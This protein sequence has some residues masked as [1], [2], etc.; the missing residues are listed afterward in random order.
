MN[1][2]RNIFTPRIG[3]EFM[4]S[5]VGVKRVGI[6]STWFQRGVPYQSRFLSKALSVAHDVYIFAYK[7]LTEDER[8]WGY[9]KLAFSKKISS[10]KVINWIKKDK[11]R[12]IFFPD[13]LEDKKVLAFCEKANIATIMVINYET[14]CKED[15][16]FYERYTRLL[17]PVKCT[18]DALER[19]GIK[20]IHF[21]RWAVD[22]SVYSPGRAPEGRSPVRFIHNA[23]FGGVGFRKNTEAVVVAFDKASRENKNIELILKTQKPLKNYPKIISDIVERNPQIS[24]NEKDLGL[25]DLLD[26]TRSCHVSLLPSKWEGIGLPFLESLSMGLPVLTVDAPP[27]NEWV[28]NDVTGYCCKVKEWEGKHREKNIVKAALV[29]TDDYAKQILRFSNLDLVDSM[30]D[31][32]IAS[33]KQWESEFLT[34]I[35]EFTDSL[36]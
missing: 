34:K 29:D 3:P 7:E 24:A 8:D 19:M 1:F 5:A 32:S 11:P 35:N 4:P 22:T 21:I 25:D 36:M 12:V 6:V 31:R 26:L 2:F 18:Y 20:N 14:I 10:A 17:C 33:A 28:V 13:R 27:M 16:G 9:K 15:F 23:G 30:R